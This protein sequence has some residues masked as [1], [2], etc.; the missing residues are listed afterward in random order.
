MLNGV[1]YA[2]NSLIVITEVGEGDNALQCR[3]DLFNGV[4]HFPDRSLVNSDGN[5]YRTRGNSMLVSLNRR[6]GATQPTGL[7]CC[8]APTVASPF[9]KSSICTT[10][11]K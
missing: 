6:N 7:Y 4:W 1:S 2:N 9:I 5:I 3:T 11:S 8:E 10:L